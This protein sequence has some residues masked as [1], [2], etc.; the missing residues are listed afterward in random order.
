M[1][2]REASWEF[3]RA[4]PGNWIYDTC[5]EHM[6]WKLWCMGGEL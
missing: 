5:D 1:R 3:F 6:H 4:W 2:H